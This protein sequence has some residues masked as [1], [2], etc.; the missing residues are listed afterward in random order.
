MHK[1]QYRPFLSRPDFS[2]QRIHGTGRDDKPR[3]KIE[4]H[5]Q[6]F[7]WAAKLAK[8]GYYGGDP[9]QI[10]NAPVSIIIKLLNFQVFEN[11]YESAYYDL[12]KGAEQ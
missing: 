8:A 7:F 12:N 9:E 3:P 11:E 4:I 2:V 1:G 6:C 10:L 5:D